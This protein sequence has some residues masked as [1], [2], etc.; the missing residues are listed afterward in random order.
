MLIAG[1]RDFERTPVRIGSYLLQPSACDSLKLSLTTASVIV[2]DTS[3]L[4]GH[5]FATFSDS[6]VTSSLYFTTEAG[7]IHKK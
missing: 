6:D 4:A 5:L 3:F 1:R 2:V 7:R